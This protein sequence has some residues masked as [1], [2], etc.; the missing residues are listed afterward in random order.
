LKN[1]A[2]KKPSRG[3]LRSGAGRPSSGTV[4]VQFKLRSETADALRA[5]IPTKHRSAF[6]DAAIRQA[7]EK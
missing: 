5:A 6:A 1:S 4:A 2:P 7:L 3:G